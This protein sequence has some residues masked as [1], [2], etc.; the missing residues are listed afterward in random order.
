MVVKLGRFLNYIHKLQSFVSRCLHII[1][2][3]RWPEVI[4]NHDFGGKKQAERRKW[5]R[6]GHTLRKSPSDIKRAALEW[7]PQGTRKRGRPRTTWQQTVLNEL[8][9]DKKGWA[10]VKTLAANRTRW[11]TVTQVLCST[12]E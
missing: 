12:E 9:P 4:L 10:E 7:N 2:N 3:C 11:Q 1:I 5:K 6:I 8:K